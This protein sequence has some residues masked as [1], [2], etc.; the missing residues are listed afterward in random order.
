MFCVGAIA[1][2]TPLTSG[3]QSTN[4]KHV[5]SENLKFGQ[6]TFAWICL[7]NGIS[8]VATCCQVF[9][10]LWSVDGVLPFHLR[11]RILGRRDLSK[12]LYRSYTNDSAQEGQRARSQAASL[13]SRGACASYVASTPRGQLH[14]ACLQSCSDGSARLLSCI[15]RHH[16]ILL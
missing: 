10:R 2:Q 9:A 15:R 1:A 8:C 13:Q 6:G 4:T 12:Y 16:D 7:S 14:M 5:F 11:W 3:S